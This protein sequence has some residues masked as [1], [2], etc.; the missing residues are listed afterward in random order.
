[1][2]ITQEKMPLLKDNREKKIQVAETLL[3]YTPLYVHA[4]T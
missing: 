1:M 2:E 4:F 3:T